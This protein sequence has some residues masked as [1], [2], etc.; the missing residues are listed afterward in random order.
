VRLPVHSGPTGSQVGAA[1]RAYRTG[2][3]PASDRVTF[4]ACD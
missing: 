2:P 3:M 1:Y 4:G